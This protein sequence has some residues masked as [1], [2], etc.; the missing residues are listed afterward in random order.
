MCYTVVLFEQKQLDQSLFHAQ[1]SLRLNPA[2]LK[3][4]DTLAKHAWLRATSIDDE[5]YDPPLALKFA[6]QAIEL[7][8]GTKK[9]AGQLHVLAMAYAANGN[10]GEAVEN[11]RLA[12]QLAMTQGNK[13]LARDIQKHMKLYRNNTPYRE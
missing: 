10:F 2:D 13:Q 1:E 9:R 6:R 4:L 7:T 12:L 3:G 11:G 5:H 8:P